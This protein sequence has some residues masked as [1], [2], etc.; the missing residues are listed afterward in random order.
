MTAARR[1]AL[2]RAINRYADAEFER[3]SDGFD[4]V[5][6][7]RAVILEVTGE[8]VADDATYA[9]A[10]E[11]DQIIEDHGGLRGLITYYLGEPV[12]PGELTTCDVALV[13]LDGIPPLLGVVATAGRTLVPM[14]RGLETVPLVCASVGWRI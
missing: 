4:C 9:N 1:T 12:E 10:D 6:F 8:S 5:Q 2:R 11:A 3:S 7:A 14:P 13:H